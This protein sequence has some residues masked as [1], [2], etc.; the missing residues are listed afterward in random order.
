MAAQYNNRVEYFGEVLMD[1]STDTVT[2]ED[3]AAGKTFHDKSGAPRTG[4]S[5]LNADTSDDTVTAAA[6]LDGVTAHNAAGNPITG[7]MPDNGATGGTISALAQQVS[8]PAGYTSGGSVSIAAAEQAKAVPENIRQGVTLLGV[9][10]SMS[11]TEGMNAQAKSVTPGLTQQ[12]VMPDSGYNCL[13]QVTVAAV[14][15]TSTE[16][17]GGGNTVT[18]G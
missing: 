17:A 16:N 18:I 9:E 3:V 1:I 10:G 14:P 13:S 5:E 15:M 12:V 6:M 4:T 2:P 7:T 8:I 11:G